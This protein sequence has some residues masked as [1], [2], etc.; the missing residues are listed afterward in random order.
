MNSWRASPANAYE[1]LRTGA[2]DG[3]AW[4]AMSDMRKS[5]AHLTARAWRRVVLASALPGYRDR[6]R[7]WV[8]DSLKY[9]D[10]RDLATSGDHVPELSDVYV[11]V[12]LVSRAPDEVPGNP[13][14]RA[15]GGTPERHSISELLDR[16]SRVVLALVG[17]PGSG[18]ST[19]LAHAARRSAQT[20]V[21][22]R[23]GRRR[24]RQGTRR[25]VGAPA[26]P[27][28]VP[29]PARRPR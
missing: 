17:Q 23:L 29:G 27:R 21:R 5:G 6:Y 25:L 16:R 24:A 20:V 9:I 12:A 8:L 3:L 11:D 1:F 2:R 22:G 18:K 26:A 10:V 28:P 13:L 4:T 19:L 15:A 7:R 14:G